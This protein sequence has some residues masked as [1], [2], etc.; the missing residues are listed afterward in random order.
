[1]HDSIT[2]EQHGIPSAYVCTDQFLPTVRAM[3]EVLGLPAYPYA[4][5]EHPIG[6]ATDDQLRRKAESIADRVCQLLLAR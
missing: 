4:A 5:V 6:R 1:M 2:I 3:A